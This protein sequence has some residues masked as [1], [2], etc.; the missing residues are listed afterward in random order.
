MKIR[1]DVENKLSE[2]GAE[3]TDSI[4]TGHWVSI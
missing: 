1:G 4:I 3:N 2:L